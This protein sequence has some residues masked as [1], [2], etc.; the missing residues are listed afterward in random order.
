VSVVQ[1][2][3]Y[4]RILFIN[5]DDHYFSLQDAYFGLPTLR[6]RLPT[7]RMLSVGEVLRTNRPPVPEYL[8][9]LPVVRSTLLVTSPAMRTHE[10]FEVEDGELV[11]NE[12]Y[13]KDSLPPYSLWAENALLHNWFASD[14][15]GEAVGVPL[16]DFPD[17][18]TYVPALRALTQQLQY[19][20]W[21]DLLERSFGILC[22]MP[23]NAKIGKV[24]EI[25]D[26]LWYHVIFGDETRAY[27]SENP[28]ERMTL[29]TILAPYELLDTRVRVMDYVADG[30]SFDHYKE[31]EEDIG[32]RNM[33]VI[34]GR[35]GAFRN[36]SF[37]TLLNFVRR[38][39]PAWQTAH[40]V[41]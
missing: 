15:L 22:G 37:P 17:G 8:S 31:L 41:E 33:F 30:S 11:L 9:H 28:T 1:E 6:D 29:G 39:K 25:V 40:I 7:L 24:S 20:P 12:P 26:D 3:A 19:G 2:S 38:A 35:D 10:D 32:W 13:T 5:G 18:D 23:F 36:V 21:K 4:A 16:S 14:T 27:R 34:L